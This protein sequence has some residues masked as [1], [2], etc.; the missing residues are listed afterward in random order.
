MIR[1]QQLELH[2]LFEVEKIAGLS[3]STSD[4]KEALLEM[5]DARLRILGTA[6]ADKQ[7]LLGVR[8]ATMRVSM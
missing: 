5:L 4:N 7:Y 1:T 2:A 8:R 3:T 6:T